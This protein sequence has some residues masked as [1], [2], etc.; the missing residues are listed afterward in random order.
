[1]YG[2]IHQLC[3]TTLGL[4]KPSGIECRLLVQALNEDA[5]EVSALLRRQAQQ[6]GF[7]GF[8]GHARN[9]VRCPLVY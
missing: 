6:L 5:G 1:L 4:L 9:S 3:R 2:A 7:K 8:A